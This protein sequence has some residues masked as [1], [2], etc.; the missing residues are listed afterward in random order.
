MT[1]V[2]DEA[3]TLVLI[4]DNRCITVKIEDV[5]VRTER[6]CLV[7]PYYNFSRVGQDKLTLML[8]QFGFWTPE[9]SYP[10]N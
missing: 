9:E 5:V 7:H 3:K 4:N 10:I 2:D 8:H 1:S 6:E